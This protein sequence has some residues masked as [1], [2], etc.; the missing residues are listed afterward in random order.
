MI[1]LCVERI[2][3]GWDDCAGWIRECDIVGWENDVF[4]VVLSRGIGRFNW[5][6]EEGMVCWNKVAGG[7]GWDYMLWESG[8]DIVSRWS[9]CRSLPVVS[10][11]KVFKLLL[12]IGIVYCWRRL[13]WNP[14]DLDEENELKIEE[15]GNEVS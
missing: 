10:A 1:I 15:Y 6:G 3:L 2:G 7:E 8:E 9:E 13:D 4:C 11:S 5:V 12:E 14:E